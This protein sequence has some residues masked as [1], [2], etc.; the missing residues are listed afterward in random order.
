MPGQ[1]ADTPLLDDDS[2][3]ARPVAETTEPAQEP[4]Q[5]L[6]RASSPQEAFNDLRD[7]IEELRGEVGQLRG[8]AEG[9]NNYLCT[10]VEKHR[11]E[12][13]KAALESMFQLH[14]TLY[15]KVT[16][17]VSGDEEPNAFVMN[18]LENL[19]GELARHG[20]EIIEP[21]PGDKINLEVM[22][23]AGTTRCSWWR[24]PDRV[25]SVARC[26]YAREIDGRH[27]VIRKA[28]VTIYRRIESEQQKGE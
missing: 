21:K 2:S 4:P 6:A 19:Q 12:G 23:L 3:E 20:V 17:M 1:T 24:N 26:G 25:S 15:A 22:F 27:E 28:D 13:M 16:V 5:E 10:D 8:F 7:S 18:C 14:D 11:K 9:I